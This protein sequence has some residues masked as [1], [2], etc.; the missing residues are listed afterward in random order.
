MVKRKFGGNCVGG[1]RQEEIACQ[2]AS[3]SDTVIAAPPNVDDALR[4]SVLALFLVRKVLWGHLS[5]SMAQEIAFLAISDGTE[6]K[7]SG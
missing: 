1:F 3:S 7:K 6:G 4:Y 2:A 5:A